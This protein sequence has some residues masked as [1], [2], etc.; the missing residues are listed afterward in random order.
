MSDLR[1]CHREKG[2]LELYVAPRHLKKARA[3]RGGIQWQGSDEKAKREGVSD[4]KEGDEGEASVFLGK[5][6]PG[7]R[8]DTFACAR[9]R[10]V[11]AFLVLFLSLS[12]S[13]SVW[14][15]RAEKPRA[16]SDGNELTL[17]EKSC[18]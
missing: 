16:T 7:A 15:S 13:L 3:R 4:E 14:H 18:F 9:A 6:R 5:T 12:L 11:R 2:T 17:Y 1:R 8:C 10:G